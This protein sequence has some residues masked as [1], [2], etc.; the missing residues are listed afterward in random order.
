MRKNKRKY[1]TKVMFL[2]NSRTNNGKVLTR[3]GLEMG[4]ARGE[5]GLDSHTQQ[6]TGK[7][8]HVPVRY[9]QLQ[10]EEERGPK[11]HTASTRVR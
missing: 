4:H 6:R 5:V 7:R 11:G 9:A 10:Q 8:N 3:V 2:K 1:R